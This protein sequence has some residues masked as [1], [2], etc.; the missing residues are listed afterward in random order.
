MVAAVPWSATIARHPSCAI[1]GPHRSSEI[2][3]LLRLCGI[4]ERQEG[5]KAE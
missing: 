1:I 3:E 5:L 4:T 2:I